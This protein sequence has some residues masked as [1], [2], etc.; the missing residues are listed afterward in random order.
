MKEA[1]QKYM[2]RCFE[3]ARKGLGFTRT[4]PLVGSVIVHHGRIIGEGYH[5]AFGG[6]HAEVLAIGSVE[7]PSLLSESTLYCSLE[8]CSH[9]G[10]TPPCAELIVQKGI[11]RVVVANMDPFPSVNGRG[12]A[13][14]REAGVEVRIGCLEEEGR[15]LN[16][17]FFTFVEKRRPF[18]VLK[19]AQTRDGFIDPER[20]PG[21]PVGPNWITDEVCRTL[22]H[23][24][25]SE[26]AAILAG[27][28]TIIA[29]DPGLNVRRWKGE[30]PLRV[31][32]DRSGRIP[33]SARILDGTQATLIFTGPGVHIGG[34]TRSIPLAADVG[35]GAVL[36]AL[37]EQKIISLF[38]EGGAGILRSFIREGLWDEARVFTASFDYGGGVEAPDPA[39]QPEEE[40]T[41]HFAN[42]KLYRNH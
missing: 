28:N 34:K 39:C 25:R 5:H 35:L 16:R 15:F 27:T 7:D 40:T 8:P 10:K 30:Q 14:L 41:L 12:I 2:R 32:I 42:L 26:E 13:R 38:V 36:E 17:R 37:F 19:W 11:P 18:V 1:D 21:D 3:L 6:P 31:S 29:D 4:N 23:K 20:A 22:V 24:W 9:Q 33:D